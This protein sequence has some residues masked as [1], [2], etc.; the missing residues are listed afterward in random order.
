MNQR[1]RLFHRLA[2]AYDVPVEAVAWLAGDASVVPTSALAEYE[3]ELRALWS[4]CRIQ[5]LAAC[6]SVRRMPTG[7]LIFDAPTERRKAL[8]EV[9][10]Q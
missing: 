1:T 9:I 7:Y 4:V 5:I 2:L 3:D 8:A 10:V 6:R